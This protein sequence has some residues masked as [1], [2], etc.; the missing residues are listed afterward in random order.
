MSKYE[1]HNERGP[2]VIDMKRKRPYIEQA[3]IGT[4]L[5]FKLPSGKA[6]SAAIVDRDKQLCTLVVETAYGARYVISYDDVLWVRTGKRW[7][8]GVYAALTEGRASE[9]DE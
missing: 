6:R 1:A 9:S 2:V 5:A 4:L 7:P 8:A 3:A